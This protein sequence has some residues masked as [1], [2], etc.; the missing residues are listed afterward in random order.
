LFGRAEI[1][2]IL[3]LHSEFNLTF[4][5]FSRL[6]S[7]ILIGI[8]FGILEEFLKKNSEVIAFFLLGILEKF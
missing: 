4:S 7:G 5:C 2:V 3:G 1:L 6:K 8:L